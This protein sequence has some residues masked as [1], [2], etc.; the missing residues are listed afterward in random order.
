MA[1]PIPLGYSLLFTISF[2]TFE[3]F[4]VVVLTRRDPFVQD[5]LLDDHLGP[6]VFLGMIEHLFGQMLRNTHD[7]LVV[8]YDQITGDYGNPTAA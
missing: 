7:A 8:G 4:G 1:D 6:L 2:D 3:S 5:H